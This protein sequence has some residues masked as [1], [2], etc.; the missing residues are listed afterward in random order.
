MYKSVNLFLFNNIEI[1]YQ[2]FI[3]ILKNLYMRTE[4][5]PYQAWSL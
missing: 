2:L 5:I 3:M 1:L 4:S